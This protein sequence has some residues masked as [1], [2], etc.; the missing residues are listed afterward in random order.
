MM[1][2][3]PFMHNSGKLI[4]AS[5]RPGGYGGMD[6][7]YSKELNGKWMPPVRLDPPINS[8]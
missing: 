7:Y 1:S 5:K 3:I 2:Y 8:K 4:F 6:V